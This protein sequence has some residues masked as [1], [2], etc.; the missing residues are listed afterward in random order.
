MANFC[1]ALGGALRLSLHNRGALGSAPRLR[2]SRSARPVA[3]Y[4][5]V[6]DGPFRCATDDHFPS[7]DSRPCA[8]LHCAY[9][10]EPI[11]QFQ[12]LPA[13]TVLQAITDRLGVSRG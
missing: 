9:Q 6:T 10:I 3:H 13:D 5:C 4:R 7:S 8:M 1:G 12:V 11:S 2:D